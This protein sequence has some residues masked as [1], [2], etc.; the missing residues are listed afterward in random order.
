MADL[1]FIRTIQSPN[2]VVK[3]AATGLYRVSSKAFSPS[4]EDKKLSGDLE[5]LL[6]TDGLHAT[7]LRPALSRAVG[8]FALTIGK[9]RDQGLSVAHDP[10]R[11]NWY[12]GAVSGITKRHQKILSREAIELIAIDQGEVAKF[13]SLSLQKPRGIF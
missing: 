2:H 3:D 1:H 11:E 8:A 10:V 12:H 6:L 7:S 4:S 5:Q 13:E 9:L